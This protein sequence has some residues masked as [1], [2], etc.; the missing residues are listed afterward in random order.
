MKFRKDINGLRAI[1]VIA[2][3][4]FHFNES[5][6]P[7]G[8]A[9]VDVF[10]VI[11]GFLM[12]GIIFKGI[13]NDNFSVLNFY[14]SRANRIFPALAFLCLILLV[15]GWFYI[16]PLDY[17]AL[18]KHVAS[19][20]TFL[21]NVVY[22]KESGYF[23][24][25]SHGKWLLHTWSLSAEWQFYIIYPLVLVSMRKFMS[26]KVMKATVLFGTILG[27]VFCVIA[28]YKWPNPAY[29]LL[30]TRAWELMVGG[31]AYLYPIV[32]KKERKKILEL[33]GLLLIVGSYFL[34]SK[35]NPWPGYLA[36]FPVLGSFFIIQSQRDDSFFTGNIVSQKIGMWSYSIYLWHWPLVVV[37]YYFSLSDKFIYVGVFLS[38]FIG[39]LSNK[40]VEGVKLKSSFSSFS[41]Y[42]KCKPVYI[43]LGVSVCGSGVFF[44]N[45]F[46][47]HYSDAVVVASNESINR[48]PYRC[49]NDHKFPC[50]IGNEKNI[51]AIIVGDS[52]ADALTTAVAHSVDL[53]KE[54]V[55][56]L[57]MSSCPFVLNLMSTKNGD[58]CYKE[59]ARRIEY[60]ESNYD[61][62]PV[63]LVSRM[64][65]YLY[66]QS[67]PQRVKDISDIQPSVYFT[68]P[69]TKVEDLLYDELKFN[70][71]LT[72]DKLLINHP[73]YIVQP[74][75][76]M[77][78]NVPATLARN[79]LLDNGDYDLSID[80]GLYIQRNERLRNLINEVSI[81]KNIVVLDPAPYLCHND[82][83]L[84]QIKGRPIY[85][86]GDHMSEY[87]NKLLTPM[88]KLVTEKN[89]N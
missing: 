47:Y 23:D 67:N 21:S 77:R 31:V 10:F 79:L 46:E 65:A 35:D 43:L 87:G 1:A 38:L 42:L 58:K 27:F 5:W 11:S 80:Y 15:F 49:M 59:N 32:L 53:K 3:V 44:T 89:I 88:F 33:F 68:K 64:G 84:A 48:N 7:G 22:W 71:S 20:M 70:L 52:H 25:V 82:R 17:K 61:S 37:I 18:G 55:I 19:S 63:I 83:C 62:V 16:T 86:D 36:F 75:P 28:T 29:Y 2:V 39:F 57:T 81:K 45:G 76:E 14:I 60:L 50:Y 51:K 73:V 78:K 56:A 24:A 8:F 6:M 85:Y 4:F 54:G 40:Y 12:T 66:G 9:G 69:Y 74:T 34:I 41:S 13:E 72:V 26:V 30:P